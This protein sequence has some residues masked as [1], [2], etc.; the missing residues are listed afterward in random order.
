MVFDQGAESNGAL[1][2]VDG[3]AIKLG[4]TAETLRPMDERAFSI[5]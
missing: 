3:H 5:S 4:G 2:E 1:S